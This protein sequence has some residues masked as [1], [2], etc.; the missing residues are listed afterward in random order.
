MG[1]IDKKRDRV[2]ERIKFLEDQLVEFLTKKTSNIKEINVA[3][4]QEKIRLLN[5]ELSKLK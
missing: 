4:Q 3:E 1:K 5:I 2:K